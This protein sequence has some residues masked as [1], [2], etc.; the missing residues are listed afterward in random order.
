MPFGIVPRGL[1]PRFMPLYSG[2]A[3]AG[4]DSSSRAMAFTQYPSRHSKP[5]NTTVTALFGGPE[6][7]DSGSPT[8]PATH[9]HFTA[10]SLSTKSLALRIFV[11]LWYFRNYP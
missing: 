6:R 11:V 3:M 4:L 7:T 1:D 10:S 9:D 5:L 8:S 2:L